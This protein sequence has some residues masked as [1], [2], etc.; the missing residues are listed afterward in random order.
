MS[1]FPHQIK[2]L[3]VT[4]WCRV[5]NMVS[6][7]EVLLLGVTGW[8]R[9]ANMVSESEVLSSTPSGRDLSK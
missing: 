3:G 4:G 8:C 9:V 6:E 1:T 7:S 5:A 2:F